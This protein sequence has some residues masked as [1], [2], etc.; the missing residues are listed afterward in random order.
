MF[1]IFNDNSIGP[2]KYLINM[3]LFFFVGL[4]FSMIKVS[5]MKIFNKFH[6]FVV[7]EYLMI[8]ISALNNI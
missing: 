6:L 7:L 3:F 1:K 5:A 4:R 8:T 2:K